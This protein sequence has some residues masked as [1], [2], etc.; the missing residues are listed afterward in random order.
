MTM[1][2]RSGCSATSRSHSSTSAFQSAKSIAVL[3]M[4]SDLPFNRLNSVKLLLAFVINL[5]AAGFLAFSGK[6]VWSLVLV[7][8][9]AALIGGNLGGRLASWLPPEKLRAFVVVFGF[10]VAGVYFA[11]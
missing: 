5:F 9:P 6:V 8:A 4:F 7:M 3:G 11:K 1:P 2:A 10:V